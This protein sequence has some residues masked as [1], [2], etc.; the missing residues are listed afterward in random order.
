MPLNGYKCYELLLS[1]SKGLLVRCHDLCKGAGIQ[2]FA[3]EQAK[4][5]ICSKVLT[6]E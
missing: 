2:L 1:L 3:T 4:V 5:L 6:L